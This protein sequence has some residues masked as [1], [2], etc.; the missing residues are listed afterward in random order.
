MESNQISDA[1]LSA[2]FEENLP[3]SQ[4]AAIE[5]AVR[6]DPDLQKRLAAVCGREDAGLHTLGAIW[7]RYRLSCVSRETLGSYLLGVL[8]SNEADYVRFHTQDIGCRICQANLEDLQSAALEQRG[9]AEK[10][11][12]RYFQTSAGMLRGEQ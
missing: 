4:M 6:S 7:R 10:R 8:P 1:D 5:N 3:A 2:F 12:K 11:R 9:A